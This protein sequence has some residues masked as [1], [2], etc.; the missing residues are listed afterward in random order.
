MTDKIECVHDAWVEQIDSRNAYKFGETAIDLDAFADLVKETFEIIKEA[1]LQYIYR[2]TYPDD[3]H[4]VFNYLQLF[5][6]IAQ[7]ST[8]DYDGDESDNRAFTATCLVA[9]RL[10]DYA[11]YSD[12]A[13]NN[14][15][16]LEYFDTEETLAGELVILRADYPYFTDEINDDIYIYNVYTGD[17]SEVLKLA[18][19]L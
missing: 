1:K 17:F 18:K 5:S 11:V 8:Y 16:K 4:T 6:K 2:S 13:M 15:G 10:V 12:G 19:E 9:Q 3:T 7:Y 14:G